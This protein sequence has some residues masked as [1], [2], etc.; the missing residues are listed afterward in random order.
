MSRIVIVVDT[1]DLYETTLAEQ[2]VAF[3]LVLPGWASRGEPGPPSALDRLG[4]MKTLRHGRI[5]SEADAAAVVLTVLGGSSVVGFMDG[6]GSLVD[7]LLDDLRHLGSV[8]VRGMDG[9]DSAGPSLDQRTEGGWR[10]EPERLTEEE[11]AALRR[12]A[13]GFDRVGAAAALNLSTRTL[14]RRLAS[15][16]RK[17]GASTLAQA[18]AA[19]S[20]PD[21]R[22]G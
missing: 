21:G 8:E 14:D 16:R 3:D 7:R 11:L 22:A 5:A 1:W 2:R 15:A 12:L 9:A 10:A 6:P 20:R 13:E 18:V 17:L 4:A 19:I